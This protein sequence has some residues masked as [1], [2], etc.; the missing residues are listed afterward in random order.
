[1]NTNVNTNLRMHQTPGQKPTLSA[2]TKS[3]LTAAGGASGAGAP[4][5]ASW[6]W[7]SFKRNPSNVEEDNICGWQFMFP[8]PE[9]LP[10]NMEQRG[11]D[12][13]HRWSRSQ[14]WHCSN[15]RAGDLWFMPKHQTQLHQLLYFK[16]IYK[17]ICCIDLG[18]EMDT[19]IAS[20]LNLI[21]SY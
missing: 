1:M 12:K 18:V 16:G 3:L 21:Y 2:S 10:R 13:L 5:G 17:Q 7:R 8:K 19:W 20:P 15:W 4:P 9:A 6:K 14:P 11:G